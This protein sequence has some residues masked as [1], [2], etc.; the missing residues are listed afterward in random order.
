M[1]EKKD[2]RVPQARQQE[3]PPQQQA[4]QQQQQPRRGLFTGKQPLYSSAKAQE[5]K[6][7][8]PTPEGSA[9]STLPASAAAAQ[10]HPPALP[11]IDAATNPFASPSEDITNPFLTAAPS[12]I[13]AQPARASGTSAMATRFSHSVL[14]LSGFILQCE[15]FPQVRVDQPGLC[16]LILSWTSHF[17]F[18]RC[19]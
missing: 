15:R 7:A 9:R 1:E 3:Y 8:A 16:Q 13:H 4:Q 17:C 5:Q 2:F 14:L 19:L 6:E 11:D 18:M 12:Q 10:G